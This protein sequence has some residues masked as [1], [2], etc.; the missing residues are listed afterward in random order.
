MYEI[1]IIQITYRKML[2]K[3]NEAKKK[4]QKQMMYYNSNLLKIRI[5]FRQSVLEFRKFLKNTPMHFQ[6]SMTII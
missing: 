6:T 5:F 3:T 1:D 2:V 4:I